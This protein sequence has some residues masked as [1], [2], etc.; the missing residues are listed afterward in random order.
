[1]ASETGMN[2]VFFSGRPHTGQRM[3]SKDWPGLRNRKAGG[4]RCKRRTVDFFGYIEPRAESIPHWSRRDVLSLIILEG[5]N[6]NQRLKGKLI[7]S[8]TCLEEVLR[9]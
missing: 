1:M 7:E 6:P 2:V 5:Q 4:L 9:S 3:R 8:G